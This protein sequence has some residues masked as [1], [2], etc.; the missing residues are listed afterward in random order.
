[1][2]DILMEVLAGAVNGTGIGLDG[3]GLQPLEI[4][5]LE[6]SLAVAFERRGGGGQ[7]GHLEVISSL[8]INAPLV[9]G[10]KATL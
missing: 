3:L 1:V 7:S 10:D 5:V 6:V 9:E 4:Q 2:I 8:I